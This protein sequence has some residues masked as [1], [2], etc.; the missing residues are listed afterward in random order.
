[1][2]LIYFI[3][4]LSLFTSQVDDYTI[5]VTEVNLTIEVE[6]RKAS[7]EEDIFINSFLNPN[8]KLLFIKNNKFK[9]CLLSFD[10]IH[11][12]LKLIP[13]DVLS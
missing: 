7:N 1:M 5:D 11:L 6:E 8:F 10:Q 2:R 12:E 13:P 3:L 9:F 4:A